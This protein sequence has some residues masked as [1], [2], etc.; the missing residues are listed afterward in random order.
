MKS[1]VPSIH[2]K[3]LKHLKYAMGKLKFT[4]KKISNTRGSKLFL[5]LATT[6]PL[7]ALWGGAQLHSN[8]EPMNNEQRIGTIH[9]RICHFLE[10]YKC[11]LEKKNEYI[12]ETQWII[13][14]RMQ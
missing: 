3:Y 12:L 4:H 11:E 5:S 7:F 1:H 8:T 9:L 14:I 10:C 6:N 2:P 13:F